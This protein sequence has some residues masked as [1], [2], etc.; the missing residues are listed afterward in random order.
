M[1][2]FAILV[3]ALSA[4][5]APAQEPKAYPPPK[6]AGPVVE[7][8]EDLVDP[9]VAL[10][11]NPVGGEAG[12][13]VREDLQDLL[14]YACDNESP[15]QIP[16][17]NMVMGH[18]KTIPLIADYLPGWAIT[19]P[20]PTHNSCDRTELVEAMKSTGF[21]YWVVF[22]FN[23]NQCVAATIFGSKSSKTVKRR[24]RKF[25][26]KIGK[27]EV[28][29]MAWC[30]GLL[31]RGFNIITSRLILASNSG[32]EL[33]SREGWPDLGPVDDDYF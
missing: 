4:T 28:Q 9:L 13:A 23:A 7:L 12:T 29:E 24:Y 19:M 3:V 2:R 31:D 20:K 8:F 18:F 5:L 10:L 1:T 21:K 32:S 16:V 17:I 15:R 33:S 14:R 27:E 11:T 26:E 22:G 30:P 6:S 25:I